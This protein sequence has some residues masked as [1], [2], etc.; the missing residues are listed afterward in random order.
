MADPGH[1][2]CPT[3]LWWQLDVDLVFAASKEDDSQQ[4]VCCRKL[5]FADLSL[6]LMCTHHT[7]PGWKSGPHTEVPRHALDPQ[8]QD[9]MHKTPKHVYLHSLWDRESLL[10]IL[11]QGS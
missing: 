4:E 10:G 1:D 7:I 2:I 6:L 5:G 8:T 9:V 3:H 11:P